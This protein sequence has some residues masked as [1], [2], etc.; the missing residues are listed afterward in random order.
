VDK[1]TISFHHAPYRFFQGGRRKEE[2]G[3]K[4]EEGKRR[5]EREGKRQATGDC[6]K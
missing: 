6:A 4:K 2:G 1:G 3:R 5:K